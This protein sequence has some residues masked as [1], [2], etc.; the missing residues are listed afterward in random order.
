[1]RKAARERGT[2]LLV[3]AGIVSLGLVAAFASGLAG[4]AARLGREGLS[5]RALA[6]AREALI[7]YATGRPIDAIVGPGYLP[8]PDLDDD[9][10]AEP[11]CGSQS[12]HTGQAQR[13][14]RLPW[15]TLGVPELRDGYGEPLWYAVSSK[16]KG[17]LNCAQSAA[18]VDMGPDAAL[19]TI[20]LR[21]S[22]GIVV[23]DG[24]IDE[25][26][27]SG[28]SGAAAVVI[29]PGPALERRED[30]AGTVQRLQA[31]DTPSARRD[32]ANYLDK[33]PGVAFEGEDNADFVDR[34]DSAGRAGNANGFIR[35]P[36]R[37]ADGSGAVNDRVAVV[38][39][40]DLMP[41]VMHRVAHEVAHCVRLHAA[42]R[43]TGGRPAWPAPVCRQSDPEAPLAWAGEAGARFGR[44]PSAVLEACA[45]ASREIPGWWRA[46]RLHVFYA[47]DVQPVDGA[48]LPV[49]ARRD[50]AILVAGAPLAS[51]AREGAGELDAAQWLEGPHRELAS[52][53]ANPPAPQCA[54]EPGRPAC[55]GGGCDRVVVAPRSSARND[56]A[57]VTP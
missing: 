15:K 46:W 33:A 32:P 44:V 17:L 48:L 49:G 24:R 52:L 43:G 50:F 13:L 6:A 5:D 16:H 10:W 56:V 40:E 47:L 2:I 41:R 11:T 26:G 23:H 7:A 9:G 51:Q 54:P 29:A 36:V 31:R 20:T 18:C 34:N 19:G 57:V 21:D 14:G 1:M 39:Y 42:L 37:L 53:N 4:Q 45:L 27:R 28:S 22:S 12:G 35:G 25:P 3:L 38:A 8:C 55:A 30:V